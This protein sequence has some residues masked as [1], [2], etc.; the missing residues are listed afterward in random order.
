MNTIK[1]TSNGYALGQLECVGLTPRESQA[2]LLRAHGKSFTD[3]ATIMHCS[4]SSTKARIS[5][6]VFKLGIKSGKSAELIARAFV[7]GHLRLM[8]LLVMVATAHMS[9]AHPDTLN[10]IRT[11]RIARQQNHQRQSLHFA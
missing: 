8:T 10:V 5:N 9:V 11:Q 2:L 3:A 1:R 7:L 6:I 4:A